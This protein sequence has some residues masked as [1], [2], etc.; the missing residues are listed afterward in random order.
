MKRLLI[1]FFKN[2]PGASVKSRKLAKELGLTSDHEYAALKGHLHQLVEEGFLTRQGKKYKQALTKEDR[3]VVG[4][5]TIHKGG[6]GFVIPKNSKRIGDVFVAERNLGTA[7]HGDLVETTLLARQSADRSKSLE[8][9]VTRVVSRKHADI[10]GTLKRSGS[11]YIVRPD[12]NE[13]NRNIY[14]PREELLGA[15]PGDKVVVGEIVWDNPTLNPEGKVT[16]K[17][18]KAGSPDVELA[19][20]AE[21]FGLSHIFAEDALA[22]AGRVTDEI[23]KKELKKRKDIR[24]QVV[25]TIDPDDAKDFDDALSIED[26]KGGHRVGVHIADVGHYIEPGS[27][28]DEEAHKR[29]NS[30]YLVGKVIPML[31]ENLS[32]GVC[33]LKPDVDRLA[34][35]VFI[36]LTHDGKVMGSSVAK[37]AINNKRRFTY[38]EAQEV[39][40]SGKGDYVDT[41]RKLNGVAQL[42]RAKRMAEGS[43]NFHSDEV[44]FELDEDGKP[45]AVK[46]K[47]LKESNNLVEEFMLLANKVV[48]ARVGAP[49]KGAPKPFVYRV[50]DRPD[51]E[52]ITEFARF[53]KSL[54]YNVGKPD[55]IS[56]RTI[57]KLLEEVKDKPEEAIVNEV[58]IRSMAKAIY[59]TENIGHYG[60]GFSHYSHFT[61][62]IRRYADLVV[63]RLLHSYETDQTKRAP[64]A[65][66]LEETCEH[67]SFTERNAVDAERRSVKLK[68]IEFLADRV[69]EEFDA[70]ISGVVNFGLFVKLE[71]TLAEGLI[72][73]RD[74]DDDFYVFD[75]KRYAI[76]GRKTKRSIRLGDEL[77]VKL[78]RVDPDRAELDFIPVEDPKKRR[79]ETK[80][81]PK[82]R[83]TA[84]KEVP[85]KRGTASKEAP[86]KR[87]TSSKSETKKNE[88]GSKA[89][90]S[91]SEAGSKPTSRK[92][93]R[94]RSSRSGAS[95]NSRR[96]RR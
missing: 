92:S 74:L 72:K 41:L 30:V 10:T 46:R 38:D 48:A 33:S 50:H 54:G 34:Y 27:A 55:S 80:S 45:T 9:Q 94:G 32:N 1:A 47:K 44:Y 39:I 51:G 78:V 25:I 82:K 3:V 69:G 23:P 59:T 91:K 16:R 8:G 37:T 35:S 85:K 14:V 5:L 43:V 87:G 64:S 13:I 53:V 67:I 7:F 76:V 17:L 83:G 90:P 81:T 15:E 57:N 65:S 36:D 88:A 28:L 61:S 63:H 89:E 2:N 95:G 4:E 56:P 52:K 79:T 18:G 31:P 68:Q 12:L 70:V 19:A 42:L 11:F 6:Y 20:I 58:A 84:S 96:R 22:E 73:M 66:Q 26:I 40:D 75:E 21:E 86:K 49:E 77:R 60:L 24:D 62:P 93:G 71:E 29:G